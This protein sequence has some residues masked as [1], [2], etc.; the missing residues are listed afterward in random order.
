MPKAGVAGRDATVGPARLA[1]APTRSS[2][3]PQKAIM[4]SC[5]GPVVAQEEG[6]G[7]AAGWD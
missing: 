1:R 7:R 6:G 5:G 4:G 2:Q 3:T